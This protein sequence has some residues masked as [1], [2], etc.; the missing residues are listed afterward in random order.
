MLVADG[1]LHVWHL[2]GDAII[3]AT[4]STISVSWRCPRWHLLRLICVRCVCITCHKLWDNA[5]TTFIQTQPRSVETETAANWYGDVNMNKLHNNCW[6]NALFAHWTCPW[7]HIHTS[8]TVMYLCQHHAAQL[9]HRPQMLPAIKVQ[10]LIVQIL[11]CDKPAS[12]C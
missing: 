5:S 12:C 1:W 2:Y 11:F 6:T 10:A 8:S 3:I 4:T 9:L 7:T